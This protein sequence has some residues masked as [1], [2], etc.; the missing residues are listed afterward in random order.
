MRRALERLRAALGGR[1]GRKASSPTSDTN[2]G[3]A[4][5]SASSST[6]GCTITLPNGK[7]FPSAS[8][9][10]VAFRMPA[11]FEPHDGCWVAWPRRPDVW[12]GGGAPAKQAFAG[13]VRAIRRFE[14]VTV[15][16]DKEHVEW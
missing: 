6:V 12:R 10:D 8:P 9:R 5:L 3:R 16:A 11:E 1:G 13:V 2:R 14:P 7:A 4:T 15:V